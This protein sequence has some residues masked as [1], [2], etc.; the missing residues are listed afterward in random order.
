MQR[1]R[2][3]ITVYDD[4]DKTEIEHGY[5]QHHKLALDGTEVEVDLS[6]VHSKELADLFGRYA[7][8]GKIT[9]RPYKSQAKN[10]EHPKAIARRINKA[11]REW[12]Q[13]TGRHVPN[14]GTD[15]FTKFIAE[16]RDA[17]PEDYDRAAGVPS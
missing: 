16:F 17:Q 9:K 3:I 5:H 6:P 10:P 8:G 14:R 7:E 13:I 4:L 11:A 1:T 15:A 12:A 2:V